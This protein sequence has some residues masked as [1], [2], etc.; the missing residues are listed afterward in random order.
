MGNKNH[1]VING[2]LVGNVNIDL[3]GKFW[4][5][6]RASHGPILRPGVA[7]DPSELD[8]QFKGQRLKIYLPVGK[9]IQKLGRSV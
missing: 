8:E 4:R 1:L 5:N 3:P 2:F 7:G 6:I 9:Q